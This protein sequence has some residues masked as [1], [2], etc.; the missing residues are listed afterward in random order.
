MEVPL[1][2][3][4]TDEK[5]CKRSLIHTKNNNGSNFRPCR[6]PANTGGQSNF[7]LCRIPAKTGAQKEH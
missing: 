6:I 5:F 3:S 7:Q 4:I 2:N 1:G